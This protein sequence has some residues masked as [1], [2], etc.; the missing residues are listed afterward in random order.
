MRAAADR[1]RKPYP[2]ALALRIAVE[3][4]LGFIAARGQP[5]DRRAKTLFREIEICGDGCCRVV[6][7]IALEQLQHALH[8]DIVGSELR[9]Q[10][11][12]ALVRRARVE[13]DDVDHVA[14]EHAGA[15]DAHR[16]NPQTF[17]IDALAHRG[18][19]PGHHAADVRVMRDVGDE[20]HDSLPDEHRRDDVDVG[21]MR[22]AAVVRIV[23]DELVA[24]LDLGERIAL[25]YLVDCADHRAQVYRH[26]LRQRDDLA[27]R[28]KYRGRAVGALLDV[29]RERGAHQGRAHLL[30]GREQVARDDF[31]LDRIDRFCVLAA[32]R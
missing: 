17:L 15:H 32:V 24:R 14:V 3:K 18:F 1:H 11:A 28:V 31:R 22:A 10:V 23:G 16:R 26:A 5:V 7:A 8:A 6:R 30:G 9:F 2:A 25:Q 19:R 13:Q 4:I 21:Q 29:R 12:D 20:R 27:L